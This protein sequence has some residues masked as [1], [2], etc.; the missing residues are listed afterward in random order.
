MLL[1]DAARPNLRVVR[2]ALPEKRIT[3][4]SRDVD[5]DRGENRRSD[6]LAGTPGGQAPMLVCD[7]GTWSAPGRRPPVRWQLPSPWQGRV[8]IPAA[9]VRS[10]S[11][12][13]GAQMSRALAGASKFEP[14]RNTVRQLG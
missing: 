10:R 5:V 13:P 14:E 7:D 1:Y 9:F 4:P 12:R 3:V 11:E 2:R 6:F 8:G